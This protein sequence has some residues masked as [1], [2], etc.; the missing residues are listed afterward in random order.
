[1]NDVFV[2][3]HF[4]LSALIRVAPEVFLQVAYTV[5]VR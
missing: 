3:M 5:I 4:I 2:L 1:M